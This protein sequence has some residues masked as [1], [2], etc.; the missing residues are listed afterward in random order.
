MIDSIVLIALS[1]GVVTGLRVIHNHREFFK[2]FQVKDLCSARPD[3][4]LYTLNWGTTAVCFID[5][6]LRILWVYENGWSTFNKWSLL[7]AGFHLFVAIES[8]TLHQLTN[9]LLNRKEFCAL[10]NRPYESESDG[11]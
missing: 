8:S 4:I 6:V 7:W 1:I 2:D 11:Q 5:T 3:A 9:K 10:C